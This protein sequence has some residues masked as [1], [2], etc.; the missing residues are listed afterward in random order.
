[1]SEKLKHTQEVIIHNRIQCLDCMKILESHSRHDYRTCGCPNNAMVDGG[2]DY[3][4][5]GGNHLGRIKDLS[6]VEMQ[7][8]GCS[9]SSYDGK[10]W[11]CEMEKSQEERKNENMVQEAPL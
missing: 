2:K 4:R 6:E 7:P 3:Q 11:R 5:R 1:M 8:V 9:I 10:C